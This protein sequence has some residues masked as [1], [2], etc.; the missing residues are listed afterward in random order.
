[1]VRQALL[2]EDTGEQLRIW[3]TMEGVEKFHRVLLLV[4]LGLLTSAVSLL[5]RVWCHP[6]FY[7]T[8]LLTGFSAR[9]LL[10]TVVPV[11][12][13]VLGVYRHFAGPLAWQD[14]YQCVVVSLF[15]FVIKFARGTVTWDIFQESLAHKQDLR[16]LAEKQ[17]VFHKMLTSVFDAWCFCDA[18]GIIQSSTPQL[19]ILLD[20]PG[21]SP[22][23]DALRGL[24]LLQLAI[25]DDERR[26]AESFLAS[27]AGNDT[28]VKITLRLNRRN[29]IA[30]Q[31]EVS[32][33]AIR[34]GR[35]AFLR[36]MDSALDAP[37][38]CHGAVPESDAI[39][40]A[41]Q[42]LEAEP[43]CAV[44]DS[45][46][47]ERPPA[48]VPKICVETG[49]DSEAPPAHC[50]ELPEG[51]AGELSLTLSSLSQT[52]R[53][54]TR[55]KNT[56]VEATES[57]ID[58][59]FEDV[60]AGLEPCAQSAP[61]SFVHCGL[62]GGSPGARSRRSL[63]SIRSRASRASRRSRRSARSGWSHASPSVRR[64]ASQLTG[65]PRLL[66]PLASECS[67][68]SECASSSPSEASEDGLGREVTLSCQVQ[69]RDLIGSSAVAVASLG[70]ALAARREHLRSVG[71]AG[72]AAGQCYPCLMEAWSH[73]GKAA[74]PC[75]FGLFCG[76]CH[77]SHSEEH[78]RELR[79]QQ[80]RQQ[81]MSKGAR[82]RA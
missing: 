21:S 54:A 35:Q 82:R 81:R 8:L 16:V 1:M 67:E 44:V 74:C 39:F 14:L 40:V 29:S 79:R 66:S 4:L 34:V 47:K 76:R 56:F 26:R 7:V 51:S 45:E 31:V 3:R 78:L 71:S 37:G 48:E 11:N 38:C 33:S 46:S 28:T 65:T 77:E 25:D 30:H 27:T 49:H 53:R 43:L 63:A 59:M 36:C 23:E 73:E 42:V 72:H 5:T 60:L 68:C 64:M 41:V 50:A 55:V 17:A 2:A 13:I 9:H 15:W 24:S 32:L 80:R 75:K 22:K 18:D 20:A 57:V 69:D 10:A 58:S 61:G 62:P 70:P 6:S 52:D 19:D 12:V